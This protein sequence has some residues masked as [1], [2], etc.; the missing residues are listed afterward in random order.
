[1]SDSTRPH[2]LR[3]LPSEKGAEHNEVK[4]DDVYFRIID[5][6]YELFLAF[7]LRRTTIE[8]IARKA[9]IRRPT[10][11]R[12]FSDKDAIFQ[13][14]F[15]RES[16][17]L[18]KQVWQQVSAVSPPEKMIS[19]AF[20]VATRLVMK[21]PLTSRLISSEP[22]LIIPYLTVKAGPLI[23]VGHVLTG[24]QAKKLQTQGYF[25]DLDVDFLMEM[26]ARLFIS[27]ITTPSSLIS[28]DNEEQIEKLANDFL[29]P[30]LSG[31]Q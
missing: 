18:N 16:R 8:D 12:R 13:A 26:M 21:H 28:A 15:L 27:I 9:G 6:A 1:M 7:G 11:Y 31:K 17:R 29:L 19:R 10:L 2:K 24:G 23:D 14:V 4:K 5:A 3:L 30:L 20:V 22:E 25:A